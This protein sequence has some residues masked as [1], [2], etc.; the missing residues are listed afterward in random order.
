VHSLDLNAYFFIILYDFLS[1]FADTQSATAALMFLANFPPLTA[2]AIYFKFK[3]NVH[4]RY[5]MASIFD[6]VSLLFPANS[7]NRKMNGES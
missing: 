7:I 5:N 2:I 3:L 4:E 6:L 1:F